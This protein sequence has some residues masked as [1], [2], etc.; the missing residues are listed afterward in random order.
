M[1]NWCANRL[2]VTSDERELERLRMAVADDEKSVSL[3]FGRIRPMPAVYEDAAAYVASPEVQAIF[4]RFDQ[5]AAPDRTNFLLANPIILLTADGSWSPGRL[6]WNLQN[7][8]TKW[9]LDAEEVTVEARRG[10]LI[11]E[12]PT[13]GAE[14]AAL[15]CYLAAQ[16]PELRFEHLCSVCD[17]AGCAVYQ[18]GVQV[19]RDE[20]N[21]DFTDCAKLLR[22]HGW[23]DAAIYFDELAQEEFE[24]LAGEGEAT[25]GTEERIPAESGERHLRLVAD[26]GAGHEETSID[27]ECLTDLAALILKGLRVGEPST[28]PAEAKKAAQ[29]MLAGS[30]A[31]LEAG[32]DYTQRFLYDPIVSAIARVHSRLSDDDFDRAGDIYSAI[33]HLLEEE[34]DRRRH[35]RPSSPP[36]ACDTTIDLNELGVER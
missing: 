18:S 23:E 4:A 7:W 6:L 1:P 17:L 20:T 27:D 33:L 36:P 3:S 16:Y 5:L 26:A 29:E 31:E 24:D 15:V 22:G 11:Y 10:S 28:P 14:P 32:I 12:F 25:H 8:G 13:A 35:R 30:D 9:D 34:L 2:I 21:D 19:S